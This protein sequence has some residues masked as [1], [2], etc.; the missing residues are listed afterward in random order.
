MELDNVHA[1]YTNN[2]HQKISAKLGPASVATVLVIGNFF[3]KFEKLNTCLDDDYGGAFSFDS[4]LFKVAENA[5][6]LILE[7]MRHRGARGAVSLPYKTVEGTAKEGDDYI[8]NS[9]ELKFADGQTKAEIEIEVMNRV[10][11]T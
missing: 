8:G 7:V 9:G 5:G 4:E 10:F 11:Q 3:I 6:V 2:E 1:F